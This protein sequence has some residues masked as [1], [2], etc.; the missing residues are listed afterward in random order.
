MIAGR[1]FG[2]V[3]SVKLH[4]S[5]HLMA[6]VLA[7]AATSIASLPAAAGPWLEPGDDAMRL[8][9]QLLAD[10]GILDGPVTSWPLSWPDI[11][12]DVSDVGEDLDAS[13]LAALIRVQD[14]SR[15]ESASSQALYVSLARDPTPVRGFESTPREEAQLGIRAQWIRGRWAARLSAQVVSRGED[16]HALRP[17]GTYLGVNIA[18]LMISAGWVERWWG[19]GWQGSLIL[20]NN[21]RPIPGVAI[22]R[23]HS[24]ASRLPVLRLLGRWRWSAALG[25]LER[26]GVPVTDA[27]FFAARLDVRPVPWLELGLSRTAQWCGSSRPCDLS[28]FADL[29]R[30]RDNTGSGSEPGNQLAGYDLRLRSPWRALPAALYV[31]LTGE[32]E[33][34][35]LPSKFLGL[36]GAEAWGNTRWG[37]LRISAEYADT[38]CNFSRVRPEFDCA[39]RH[40]LYPQG[41]AYQGRSI[42]HSIDGDGEMS[43][44]TGWLMRPDGSRWRLT[45]RKIDFD[46]GGADAN[47]PQGA[48]RGLKQLKN[49]DVQYNR[50]FSRGSLGIGLGFDKLDGPS[51][52]DSVVRGF[53]Q[54]QRESR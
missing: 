34:G 41:Y 30:G 1:K 23:Q 19:P 40:G 31:Q 24:D 29:L 38:A 14:A 26:S 18:N 27:R 42:G 32:D 52:H 9:I 11:S 13:V 35:A 3:A 25:F 45:V 6:A 20:S 16:R 33:A 36:A 4:G 49:L 50:A 53:L 51:A 43:S 47:A 5:I 12:R 39:Y 46:R 54:W 10:E 8:D 37:L 21:A 22:E 17:D 28:T 7:A 15:R 2:A 44:A 48:T